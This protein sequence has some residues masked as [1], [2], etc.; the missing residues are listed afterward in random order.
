MRLV[1]L[2]ARSPLP[3]A[4]AAVEVP[5]PKV[6]KTSFSSSRQIKAPDFAQSRPAGKEP[7]RSSAAPPARVGRALVRQTV[8][9]WSDFAKSDFGDRSA[10]CQFAPRNAGQMR[11]GSPDSGEPLS[12]HWVRR[13]TTLPCRRPCPGQS[14]AMTGAPASGRRRSGPPA[15]PA[16]GP[17][18]WS[19]RRSPWTR[20]LRRPRC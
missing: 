9:L 19:R 17:R 4:S 5:H 14:R 7:R 6:E 15:S 18:C 2:Y 12:I 8:P 20:R 16:P 10:N 1:F 3:G 11:G 13:T